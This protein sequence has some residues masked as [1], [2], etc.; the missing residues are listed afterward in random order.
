MSRQAVSSRSGVAGRD[1]DHRP[2]GQVIE[3]ARRG[4]EEQR[5]VVL[6]ARRGEAFADVA[7][8]RH[9]RQVA[10]ESRAEAATEVLD[11]VG[12]EAELAGRQQVEPVQAGTGALRIRI[13][14]ADAVDLSVEQVDAQRRLAAHRKDVEQRAADRE[15]SRGCHLGH[16]RVAR[17]GQ[18]QPELFE[19]ED[20]ADGQC[21]CVSV[22]EAARWKPLQ[23]GRQ[24][25]QDQAGL[26]AGQ[27]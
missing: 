26:H 14:A 25:G 16:A 21:K 6:D 17:R 5:Q 27:A 8:Q 19:V 18:A 12:G 20:L 11:R 1:R 24:V 13:E 4:L 3:Q 10:L 22:D 2:V 9:P 23:G 7:V 15:L